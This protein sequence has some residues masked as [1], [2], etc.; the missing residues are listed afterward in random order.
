MGSR[1][2]ERPIGPVSKGNSGFPAKPQKARKSLQFNAFLRFAS[3]G[4]NA[5]KR[6]KMRHVN[7]T[8][9]SGPFSTSIPEL[10]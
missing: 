3:S 8:A 4:Q 1:L 10:G 9:S 6:G 2:P 5:P 7:T